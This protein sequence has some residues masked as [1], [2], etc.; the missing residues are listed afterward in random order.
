MEIFEYWNSVSWAKLQYQRPNAFINIVE[1]GQK[2]YSVSRFGL[3]EN[4]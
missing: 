4:I 3:M 2:R 1:N